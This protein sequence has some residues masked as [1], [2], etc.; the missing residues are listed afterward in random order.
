MTINELFDR[1]YD[2]AKKLG[3]TEKEVTIPE[4]I[5]LIHSEVSE[6]LESYRNH[7]PLYW[8]DK[9]GKPQGLLSEFADV[10]IRIGHYVRTIDNFTRGPSDFEAILD[11]KL[12]YNLTRGHRHGEKKI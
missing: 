7:E 3:W 2:N 9:D 4:M 5:A 10:I 1:C 6:G 12:N 8:I 11:E